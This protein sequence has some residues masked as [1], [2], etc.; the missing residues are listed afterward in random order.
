MQFIISVLPE[1]GNWLLRVYSLETGLQLARAIVPSKHVDRD[2]AIE[3]VEGL[4][5]AYQDA[6]NNMQSWA[7][8]VIITNAARVYAEVYRSNGTAHYSRLTIVPEFW[9]MTNLGRLEQ[10]GEAYFP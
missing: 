5:Q 8:Q 2:R 6:L 10:I 1:N 7:K 9:L 4:A 3:L